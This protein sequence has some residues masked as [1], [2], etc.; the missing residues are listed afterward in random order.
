MARPALPLPAR[1]PPR[2]PSE[3]LRRRAAT[4]GLPRGIDDDGLR[5]ALRRRPRASA[6][7]KRPTS[8]SS[9]AF[10]GRKR[11]PFSHALRPPGPRNAR[12]TPRSRPASAEACHARQLV[13]STTRSRQRTSHEL[14]LARRAEEM[15]E[16]W[17]G[18]THLPFRRDVEK[19]DERARAE[20]TQ[21]ELAFRRPGISRTRGRAR[22]AFLR[23]P[24]AGRGWHG[25][26]P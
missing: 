17:F 4:T 25:R 9:V 20:R 2:P 7:A 19:A 12:V 23:R 24:S 11:S 18:S 8:D 5:P 16:A 26:V 3:R 21:L 22:R 1:L 13:R 14:P 6:L 15:R 10:R